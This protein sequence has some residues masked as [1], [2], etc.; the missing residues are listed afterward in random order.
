MYRFIPYTAALGYVSDVDTDA[1]TEVVD[2]A[3]QQLSALQNF[4]IDAAPSIRSFIF[5]LIVAIIIFIV[6]KKLVGEHHQHRA[7]A[8]SAQ[9]K[10]V[11]DWLIQAVGLT[12]IGQVLYVVVHYSEYFG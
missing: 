9:G 12:V 1:V 5:N 3:G 6:G 8:F 4:L 11:S 7:D 10:H 2:E